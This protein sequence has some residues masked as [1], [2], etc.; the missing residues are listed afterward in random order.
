MPTEVCSEIKQLSATAKGKNLYLVFFS[1]F[2]E[3]EFMQ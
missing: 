2:I 1:N 3:T